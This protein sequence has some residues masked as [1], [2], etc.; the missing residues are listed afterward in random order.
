MTSMLT[1]SSLQSSHQSSSDND[2]SVEN[3]M[4]A[5]LTEL[6]SWAKRPN[7]TPNGWVLLVTSALMIVCFGTAYGLRNFIQD[8]NS[9][10]CVTRVEGREATRSNFIDLYTTIVRVLPESKDTVTELLVRMNDRYPELDVA[11]C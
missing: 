10:V 9:D 4:K 3:Q 1:A 11:D 6:V 2:S 7:Q 5:K 8:S